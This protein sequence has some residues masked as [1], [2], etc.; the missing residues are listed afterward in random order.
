MVF[1]SHKVKLHIL[2]YTFLKIIHD[3][4]IN[5]LIKKDHNKT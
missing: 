4:D 2:C 5:K 1:I 3:K